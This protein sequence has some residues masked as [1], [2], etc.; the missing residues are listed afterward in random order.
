MKYSIRLF[1]LLLLVAGVAFAKKDP[2]AEKHADD[3]ASASTL[4]GAMSFSKTTAAP[5]DTLSFP[6]SDLVLTEIF[7]FTGGFWVGGYVNTTNFDVTVRSTNNGA[8]W[9]RDTLEFTNQLG[10]EFAARNL[11]VAIAATWI[12]DIYR[13]TD[14]GATWNKVFTYGSGAGY[15]DGIIFTGGD[16]VMAV[17]DADGSGLCVVKSTD[18]GATWTRFTNLPAT[19]ATAGMWISSAGNHQAMDAIGQNVWISVYVGSGTLPRILRT[20]DWGTTWTSGDVSL[21]GGSAQAYY[22]RS[23]NMLDKNVGWLIPRQTASGVRSFVHKTTNSGVTWSDTILV[24]RGMVVRSV[25]PVRGTNNLLGMGYVGSDPKAWWSTNGGTSWTVVSPG[26]P[27]DGSDLCFA[28]FVS[29]QL[30][31]AV[32]YFKALKF[33]PPGATVV[34]PPPTDMVQGYR[35]SQNYPNPFNPT[36]NIEFSVARASNVELKVY[37]LLGREIAT[38]VN[39]QHNPGTYSVVFDARHLSSGVYYYTMRAGDFVNTKSLVLMK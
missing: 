15:F 30:G 33:T 2:L 21:T 20:T 5:W 31:Y 7:P 4:M 8:T 10:Y 29:P 38:L 28:N 39:G 27:G 35:L 18:A 12:G 32:G 9:V 1:V 11:N 3:R 36:T 22:I 26:S 17:G 25:K 24:E 13:T 6:K 16:S 23:L 14:G 19:E 34:A 37:D